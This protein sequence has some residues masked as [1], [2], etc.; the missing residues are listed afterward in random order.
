MLV[1]GQVT[2]MLPADDRGLAYGD[3]LFETMRAIRGGVPYLDLHLRRLRHGLQVLGIPFPEEAALLQD[4][5][6]TARSVVDGVVKLIITRGSGGRGYQP[7][8]DTARRIVMTRELPSDLARWGKDGMRV[9][10]CATRLAQPA[11]LA[12]LKHLNRLAQVLASREIDGRADEGLMRDEQGRVIEGT[13]SNLFVVKNDELFTPPVD[14]GVDG[15]MRRR[16]IE[17]A[18]GEGIPVH[19]RFLSDADLVGELFLVNAVIGVCP[20]ASIEDSPRVIGTMTH[21][22]QAAVSED[23]ERRAC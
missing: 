20:V 18:M 21:R 12:G 15:V 17:I 14:L 1:D 22:L 11:A 5:Q 16:L 13:R 9:V 19:E 4:V 23:M 8:R 3:G 10:M 6:H 2:E 7:S